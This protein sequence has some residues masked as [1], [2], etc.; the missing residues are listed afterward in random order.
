MGSRNNRIDF[1][2]NVETMR[3]YFSFIADLVN[4]PSFS[5]L[6]SQSKI[7]LQ[8]HIIALYYAELLERM[9]HP[10]IHIRQFITDLNNATLNSKIY[11]RQSF[12]LPNIDHASILHKRIIA[13]NSNLYC[14]LI[15]IQIKKTYLSFTAH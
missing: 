8:K 1:W 9:H 12:F 2:G 4:C 6:C 15:E 3:F 7:H 11:N 5:S 10:P 13:R 14:N